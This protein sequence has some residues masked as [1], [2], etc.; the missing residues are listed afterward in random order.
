V[1][2]AYR[3]PDLR[4]KTADPKGSVFFVHVDIVA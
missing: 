2:A 1:K 3:A 4:Q